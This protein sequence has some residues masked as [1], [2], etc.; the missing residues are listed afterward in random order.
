MSG[1]AIDLRASHSNTTRQLSVAANRRL[2]ELLGWT[3][4]FDVGGAL[5]GTPPPGQ[6]AC[7]DQ[8]K[9]PDWTGDWRACGPLLTIYIRKI[10]LRPDFIIVGAVYGAPASFDDAWPR[11]G[12]DDDAIARRAIVDAVI[13]KLEAHQ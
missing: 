9:V 4:I 1:A 11:N 12:G 7:R 6:P 13:E 2:A 3:E 5:L 10:E 8:A